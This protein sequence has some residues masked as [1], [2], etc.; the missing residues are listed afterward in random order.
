MEFQ[1]LTDFTTDSEG[2][3]LLER[4]ILDL[5]IIFIYNEVAN[6]KAR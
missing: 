6:C 5:P 3:V 1:H 4:D 2:M